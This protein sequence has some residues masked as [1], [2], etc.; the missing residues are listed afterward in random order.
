MSTSSETR[1]NFHIEYLQFKVANFETAYNAFLGRSGLTKFMAIPHYV[2]RTS[3]TW[4]HP[5]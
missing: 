4:I 5:Q 2:M 1:E 3:Q